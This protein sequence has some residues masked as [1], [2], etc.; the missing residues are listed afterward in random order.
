MTYKRY[1]IKRELNIQLI[2]G[3]NME[4][5]NDNDRK[6]WIKIK[7][8]DKK[9]DGLGKIGSKDFDWL[10]FEELTDESA[11]LYTQLSVHRD[12]I[13]NLIKRWR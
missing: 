13:N 7:S 4:I 11:R 10:R 8:I 3:F 1:V 9:I 12:I 6:L 2:L 5:K